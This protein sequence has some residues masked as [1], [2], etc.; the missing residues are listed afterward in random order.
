MLSFENCQLTFEDLRD[1]LDLRDDA[2]SKLC[3]LCKTKWGINIGIINLVIKS[4]WQCSFDFAGLHKKCNL[5]MSG[6]TARGKQYF[7]VVQLSIL[8]I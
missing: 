7:Y 5:N 3:D 8:T 6:S 4:I 1:N 2:N